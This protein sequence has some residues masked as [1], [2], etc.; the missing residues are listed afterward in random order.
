[1]GLGMLTGFAAWCDARYA[2]ADVVATMQMQ[3]QMIFEKIIPEAE[4]PGK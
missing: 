4:R 2:K 1:M 3:V